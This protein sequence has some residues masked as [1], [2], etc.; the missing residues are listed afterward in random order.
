MA[1]RDTKKYSLVSAGEV[2]G[3]TTMVMEKDYRNVVFKV[4]TSG[5]SGTL[6]FYHAEY[7]TAPDL[8][9]ATSATNPWAA[10]QTANLDTGALT[11]GTTGYTYTTNTAVE[12]FE[13]NTNLNVWA[14]AKYTRS[15]GTITIEV[16]L[17]DNQ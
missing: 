13:L 10:V 12:Y 8:S 3:Q 5:F 16:I 15:A 4:I 9:A 7:D 6:N 2:T 1:L 11:G 14:G 17:S